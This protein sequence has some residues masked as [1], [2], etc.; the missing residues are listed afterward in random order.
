MSDRMNRTTPTAT[1]A[2]VL[3]ANI[4]RNDID[5]V[6]MA[7]RLLKDRHRRRPDV[8]AKLAELSER[9]QGAAT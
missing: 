2:N 8:R 7:I 1:K 5:Q 4:D 3:V 6:A 9:K